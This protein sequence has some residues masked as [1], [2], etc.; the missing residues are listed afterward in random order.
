V[1]VEAGVRRLAFSPLEGA[2]DYLR[3]A[4]LQALRRDDAAQCA[5]WGMSCLKQIGGGGGQGPQNVQSSRQK[6]L[7][8]LSSIKHRRV[9]LC[10]PSSPS[11]KETSF[12]RALCECL[13]P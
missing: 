3:I 2:A 11:T 10:R 12:R 9:R 4:E 8:R 13:F 7:H 5:R 6:G 1:G